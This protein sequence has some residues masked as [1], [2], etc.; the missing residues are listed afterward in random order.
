[1]KFF[2]SI[3][4]QNVKSL[5]TKSLDILFLEDTKFFKLKYW[6]TKIKKKKEKKKRYRKYREKYKD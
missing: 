5:T 1:M 2:E 4:K 3:Q 6:D